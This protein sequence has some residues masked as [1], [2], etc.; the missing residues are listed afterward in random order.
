MPRPGEKPT[1]AT[2]PDQIVNSPSGANNAIAEASAS[3][4]AARMKAAQKDAVKPAPTDINYIERAAKMPQ[5]AEKTASNTRQGVADRAQALTDARFEAMI[6]EAIN[7]GSAGAPGK[8]LS[9]LPTVQFN[10]D[11][12]PDAIRFSL[13]YTDNFE[14]P[15]YG[16][17]DMEHLFGSTLR[18]EA[19][20]MLPEAKEVLSST[21]D[22]GTRRAS[23]P[24]LETPIKLVQDGAVQAKLDEPLQ[25]SDHGELELHTPAGR[26][27]TDEFDHRSPEKMG[28]SG[29]GTVF[30]AAAS[31][32]LEVALPFFKTS[33][34]T[35]TKFTLPP[36][37]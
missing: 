2:R 6:R 32:T 34:Q 23:A 28:T 13:G 12:K 8:E 7:S 27:E 10:K 26:S 19:I 11:G 31:F 22:D 36:N 18:T 9:Q 4:T 3:L 24:L 20:D 30:G 37:G 5:L 29:L 16:P 21:T 14:T 35:P 15:G 17:A 1:E 33:R 25:H